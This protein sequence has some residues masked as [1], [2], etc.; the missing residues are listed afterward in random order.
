MTVNDFRSMI[1]RKKHTV[2]Y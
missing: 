2:E 1:V